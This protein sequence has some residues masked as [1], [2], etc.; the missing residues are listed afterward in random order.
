[1]KFFIID[2]A[3]YNQNTYK[4]ENVPTYTEMLSILQECDIALSSSKI[5][6]GTIFT[7]LMDSLWDAI[8]FLDFDN[9]LLRAALAIDDVTSTTEIINGILL[10]ILSRQ[11]EFSADSFEAERSNYITM[12]H[13]AILIKKIH[14]HIGACWLD[15]IDELAK[16]FADNPPYEAF[17]KQEKH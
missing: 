17:T 4:I 5:D 16:S 11:T 6:L 2:E 14:H 15:V 8:P 12:G 3:Q 10:P 1:M 7:T 13:C 9:K